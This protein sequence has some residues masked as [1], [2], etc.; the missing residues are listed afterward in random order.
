MNNPSKITDDEFNAT[1]F[2]MA[3][4]R[5]NLL[6]GQDDQGAAEQGPSPE[7]IE[8]LSTIGIGPLL[9]AMM[10]CDARRGATSGQLAI[11]YRVAASI[12]QR[13]VALARKRPLPY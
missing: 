7:L 9:R 12:A 1:I 10:V 2:A 6:A 13:A 5:F 11:K 8:L 4:S 3:L